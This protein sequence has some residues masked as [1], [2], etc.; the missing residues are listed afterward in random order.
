[1][2][3]MRGGAI[4]IYS[5]KQGHSSRSD[6]LPLIWDIKSKIKVNKV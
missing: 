3:K 1:M 5:H 4:L 2:V 6:I